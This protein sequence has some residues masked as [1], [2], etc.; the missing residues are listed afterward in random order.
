MVTWTKGLRLSQQFTGETYAACRKKMDNVHQNLYNIVVQFC[1][2]CVE[3]H[4]NLYATWWNC[5]CEVG[6]SSWLFIVFQSSVLS[7]QCPHHHCHPPRWPSCL[8]PLLQLLTSGLPYLP[9]LVHL[10][11][12]EAT[13]LPPVRIRTGWGGIKQVVGN[14]DQNVVCWSVRSYM[15]LKQQEYHCHHQNQHRGMPNW[16]WLDP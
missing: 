8:L 5:V 3:C 9:L 10:V 12:L 1:R 4:V 11:H 6:F 14:Q 13:P 2:C 15:H 7:S 16:T